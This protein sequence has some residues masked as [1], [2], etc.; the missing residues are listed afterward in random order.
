MT[1][2]LLGILGLA[3]ADPTAAMIKVLLEARSQAGAETAAS[4]AS[5]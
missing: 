3:P 5:S 2:T 4:P 1:G